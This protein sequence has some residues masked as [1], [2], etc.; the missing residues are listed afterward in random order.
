MAA[1]MNT[2][3]CAVDGCETLARKRG[4]CAAHYSQWRR[5]GEAKPFKYKW[6]D[7]RGAC[8]VCSAPV[9]DDS[10][11]RRFCSPSCTRI[12]YAG[13]GEA[14]VTA[15]CVQCGGEIDRRPV[16]GGRWIRNDV[17]SCRSCMHARRK[18]YGASAAD[19]AK[20][21]GTDCSLCGKPVDMAL[22]RATGGVASPSVDHVIPWSK[23]GTNDAEN[24]ALAHLGCNQ[25]K[26]DRTG[27][28]APV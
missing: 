4:W 9:P 6:R 22:T 21:D 14:S 5:T 13:K 28:L 18:G 10:H 17:M 26:S 7:E 23:G 25:L 1:P 8:D 15:T 3:P 12:H 19:L 20:R 27:W 11:T 16:E 2:R 24:L